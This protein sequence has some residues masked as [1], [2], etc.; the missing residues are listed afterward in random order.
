MSVS[1]FFLHS[2]LCSDF[3]FF[4]AKVIQNLKK[5][6]STTILLSFTQLFVFRPLVFSYQDYKIRLKKWGDRKS[7]PEAMANHLHIIPKIL[8]ECV[9]KILSS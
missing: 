1:H 6:H 3:C 2:G 5:D 7:T 8:R 9:S 4:T